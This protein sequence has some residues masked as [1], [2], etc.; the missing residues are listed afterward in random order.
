MKLSELPSRERDVLSFLRSVAISSLARNE[1]VRPVALLVGPEVLLMPAVGY[2]WNEPN[3]HARKSTYA[4]MVRATA[5]ARDAELVAYLSEA[6]AVRTEQ[7]ELEAWLEEDPGRS[8][9]Q[10]PGRLE[11][12]N[13]QCESEVGRILF[14]LEITR[15]QDNS[16]WLQDLGDDLDISLNTPD[17]PEYL[18]AEG[19]FVNLYTPN[20]L[21]GGADVR[22][23][24][25]ILAEAFLK[26]YEVHEQTLRST[27]SSGKQGS[28]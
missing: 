15:A 23:Q 18:S 2:D 4:T 12:V 14:W 24:A 1:G 21:I 28:H 26:D 25:K 9:E 6:W 10:F 22:P 27:P 16:P 7:A 3:R 20:K 8:L 17:S 5:L 13:F 11:V 19:T